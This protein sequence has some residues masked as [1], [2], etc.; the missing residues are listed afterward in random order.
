M[1]MNVKIVL[2]VL[3]V[4]FAAMLIACTQ[5][6]DEEAPSLYWNLDKGAERTAA[7]DGSYQ[8]MFILNGEQV[9]LRV[10]NGE[11]MAKIDKQGALGLTVDKDGTVTEVTHI[12]DMPQYYYLAYD[13]YLQSVGGNAVKLNSQG[14]YNGKE[15]VF[16]YDD[17]TKIIDVSDF[18]QVKG[19]ATTLQKGD[20]ITVVSNSDGSIAYVL[21]T[22]RQ[23]VFVTEK[24]YCPICEEEVTFT[25][26]FSSASMPFSSG[27]YYIEK[28]I[29]L[30]MTTT[31]SSADITLDLNGKTVT[32]VSE[33]RRFYTLGDG[34]VLNIIDTAGEGRAVVAN[35]AKGPCTDG[36]FVQM[37]GFGCEL[38]IHS[39]ILDATNSVSNCGG[40]IDNKNGVLNV[41]GGTLLGGTT[42]GVGGGA[43]IVQNEVN[44]YG[45]EIIGGNC[46]DLNG[47]KV[48]P[49]GGGCIRHNGQTTILNIYGG[50]IKGGT[51][52][53]HGGCIFINGP[54]NLYGGTITGGSAGQ[55]GGGL[56]V[57][58]QGSVNIGGDV[59]ITDNED[60]DLYFS[61][62][63]T[64]TVAE[65]GLGN[66]T[67]SIDMEKP[68]T[69]VANEVPK[70]KVGC[71]VTDD[72][73]IVR[74]A[75]GTLGIK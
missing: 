69:F 12:A 15:V 20:G 36:M 22:E 19:E 62:G 68:G 74:N 29:E 14:S 50:T 24:R 38:N 56:Y 58:A 52:E 48:N 16:K 17:N 10:P 32:M 53:Y 23:G 54:M 51:T 39:G 9:T 41:Y 43:I 35:A 61:E 44:I 49:P 59:I 75:D 33:G 1:K 13:Y 25:N 47:V 3:L 55:S 57:S 37:A 18:A 34:A 63:R 27:H 28:D 60:G 31:V 40:L 70:D 64:M 73:K 4:C 7:E 8:A 2:A 46:A 71:F 42:Y 5:E 21:V 72:G 11:M 66:A 67:L 30:G 26:W 45:G 6:R 65:Q